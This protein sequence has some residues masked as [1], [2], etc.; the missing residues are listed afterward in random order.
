[1]KEN[2]FTPK[3]DYSPTNIDENL[4]FINNI[5][6]NS[7]SDKGKNLSVYD[8]IITSQYENLT[9][10]LANSRSNSFV[11]EPI[12][13]FPNEDLTLMIEKIEGIR[14]FYVIEGDDLKT[15]GTISYFDYIGLA[16]EFEIFWDHAMFY[17]I[18]ISLE[19]DYGTGLGNNSLDLFVVKANQTGYP[20]MNHILTEALSNPFN[21]SNY[22]LLG[23]SFS[24]YE[25]NPTVLEKGQYFLVANLSIIDN[26][27]DSSFIWRGRKASDDGKTFYFEESGGWQPFVAS[28]DL[29]LIVDICPTDE[30]GNNLLFNNPLELYLQVNGEQILSFHSPLSNSG[31]Q[32]VTANTSIILE[33][34]NTYLFYRDMD[35]ISFYSV[36]NETTEREINWEIFWELP[37]ANVTSYFL[38]ERVIDIFSQ[39][40]WSVNDARTVMNKT[41]SLSTLKLNNIYRLQLNNS[42]EACNFT[43]QTTSPNYVTSLTVFSSDQNEINLGYW[44]KGD[45]YFYGYEGSKL[46]LSTSLLNNES[47]GIINFT[48][49]NPNGE[50]SPIKANISSLLKY[51]D[52]SS[53]TT[54]G[55]LDSSNNQFYTNITLD[56]S[57]E[58]SDT[59]GEWT[60][61]VYWKNGTEVGFLTKSVEVKA[62]A[63]LE[64]I[65]QV[66]STSDNWTNETLV[67]RFSGE[68]LSI[69]SWIYSLSNL[70][71]NYSFTY[72]SNEK[73][74]FNTSWKT[75]GEFSYLG[76]YYF[77]NVSLSS[78]V[79]IQ[80]IDII[81]N[82]SYYHNQSKT[83]YLRIFFKMGF[84]LLYPLENQFVLEQNLIANISFRITNET[85]NDKNII[86]IFSENIKIKMNGITVLSEYYN[87]I[88]TDEYTNISLNISKLGIQSGNFSLDLEITK[89]NFKLNTSSSEI[90]LGFKLIV[91]P[92]TPTSPPSPTNPNSPN[93]KVPYLFLVKMLLFII[94][95]ILTSSIAFLIF[96][97]LV[98]RK[99]KANEFYI[100]TYNDYLKIN[101]I[102][103]IIIVHQETSISIFELDLGS[104]FQRDSTLISGFFQAI[105]SIGN[106]LTEKG[107]GDIRKIQYQNFVVTSA[108]T[109]HFVIYVFSE[110][111]ITL[112]IDLSIQSIILW[113]EANFH[114]YAEGWNGDPSVFNGKKEEIIEKCNSFLYLWMKNPIKVRDSKKIK[115]SKYLEKQ[116]EKYLNTNDFFLIEELINKIEDD[117]ERG[118]TLSYLQ[119]LYNLGYLEIKK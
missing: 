12:S 90:T 107:S 59:P 70:N 95:P 85:D 111:D 37:S 80:S 68:K 18:N 97:L 94:L 91:N 114:S 2:N 31:V 14:D 73:I 105:S 7:I 89:E 72:I 30:N 39:E 78:P 57:F 86:P 79:G 20:D 44:I 113:F 40:D 26:S 106:E 53:Y 109:D 99:R 10:D 88:N 16:Q 51:I 29:S 81:F 75:N 46:D 4:V 96:Y 77:T 11:I 61:F 34:N 65:W 38:F 101:S 116:L 42:L 115:Q 48:L 119:I 117:I 87:V 98:I 67:E 33:I 100:S 22:N 45:N 5:Q 15:D 52:N 43:L 32:V 71:S 104:D 82:S 56:P 23:G 76:D 93:G 62:Y 50:I 19:V 110:T 36:S 41:F 47:S 64:T 108:R 21:E 60:I 103:K 74:L 9:L 102:K 49:F 25:F 6:I 55:S 13:D 118:K 83:I 84:S 92:V 112:D 63:R 54:I 58:N 24:Y 1:M 8:T 35:A 17:G 3:T 27:S 69:R 66:E 28:F